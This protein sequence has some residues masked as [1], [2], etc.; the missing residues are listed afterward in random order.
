MK[1]VYV[2][3]IFVADDQTIITNEKKDVL[4]IPF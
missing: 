2:E 4:K 3:L 1:V